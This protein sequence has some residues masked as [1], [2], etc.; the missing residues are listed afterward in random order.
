MVF[1]VVIVVYLLAKASQDGVVRGPA[2][3]VLA[4]CVFPRIQHHLHGT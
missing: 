1:E 4:H 2:V 3:R